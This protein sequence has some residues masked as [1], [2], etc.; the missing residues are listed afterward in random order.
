MATWKELRE[1]AHARYAVDEEEG[2]LTLTVGFSSG[3][4]QKII[5]RPFEALGTTLIEFRAAVC[6]LR[7]LPPDEALRLNTTMPIGAFALIGDIYVLVHRFPIENINA[8]EFEV[9]LSALIR[10]ADEF[11]LKY[12]HGK[13][14]F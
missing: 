6:R 5:V 8:N 12:S 3:R 11:E 13:D 7:D 2:S 14:E 4:S 10:M 9:P 1:F